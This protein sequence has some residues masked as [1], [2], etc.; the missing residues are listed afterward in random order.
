MKISGAVVAAGATA[1]L[2]GCSANN[3]IGGDSGGSSSTEALNVVPADATSVNYVDVAGMIEDGNVELLMNT[4][5]DIAEDEQPSYDGPGDK[6]DVLD[7][8]EDSSGL[9]PR[10]LDEAMAFTEAPDASAI[11][12]DEEFDP[13][14]ATWFTA[15]WDED[16]V[17]DAVEDGGTELGE[18]DDDEAPKIYPPEDEEFGQTYMGVIEDGEY[19]FGTENAV[20]DA[21]DV[22]TGDEDSAGDELTNAYGSVQSGLMKQATTVPD[23][24]I[25]TDS[26]DEEV[27]FDPVVLTEINGSALSIY[28][29]DEQVGMEMSVSTESEDAA[30]DMRDIVAGMIAASQQ[31]VGDDDLRQEV[32]SIQDSIETDGST[33]SMSYENSA[34]TV[35]DLIEETLNELQQGS[36]SDGATFA[37]DVPL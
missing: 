22:S 21:I 26:I 9:D 34:E 28:S 30:K 36:D 37:I 23:Q 33:V 12:G 15:E 31:A 35:A 29:S 13:Y 8:I 24:S 19:V 14:T 25:P 7:E 16:D 3:P 27:N 18:P 32:E 5:L 11:T 17:V 20:E 6:E 1:G 4:A 2:A 10:E